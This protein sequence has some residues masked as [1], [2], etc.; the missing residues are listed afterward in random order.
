VTQWRVTRGTL[1]SSNRNSLWYLDSATLPLGEKGHFVFPTFAT[2]HT[3]KAGHRIGIVIVGNLYGGNA[4]GGT[5]TSASVAQPIT[6]DTRLSKVVLPVLGGYAGI[7]G[8]GGTDA[9]TVA[10]ELGAVPADISTTTTV[11]TGKTVTFTLP[12]ATDNED[13]NPVVTCDP[14][15]GA[16][17]AVGTT[18]VSCVATDAN[19]N[20]SAPKTFKVT[21]TWINQQNGNVGGSVPATLSLTLGAPASFGPLTAGIAKDY[22]AQM[23]ANV[24]STAENAALSVADPSSTATGH[25]VNG[26]F[27]LPSAL[28]ANAGG[29]FAD[30][31]GSAAATLLKSWT[32]PASNDAVTI[33]FSQH[34]G[35][36]DAL[37]TGAYSKTLTFTLSTTQP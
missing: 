26:T 35:A 37:R 10:P 17:F 21:V 33:A 32:A 14:A 7:A 29:P 20:T 19:G 3:F 34:V 31:G 12:T 27:S 23:S 9:E 25:L 15:S 8:A 11:S 2:E 4:S 24:I 1:D 30:V 28:Q 16:N 22:A 6:L 5:P 13:P 36:N 18:T